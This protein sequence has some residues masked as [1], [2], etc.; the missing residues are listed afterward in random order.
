MINVW[1]KY[2]QARLYGNEET[3]LIMKTWHNFNKVSTPY[4]KDDLL[5]EVK[6]IW[7]FIWQDKKKVTF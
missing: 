4:K 5:K 3:D 6:F 1:T 2:G 7:N